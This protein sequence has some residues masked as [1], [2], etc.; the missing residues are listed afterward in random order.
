MVLIVIGSIIAA[1]GLP[2]FARGLMFTLRPEHAMSLRAR[3]RNLRLGLESDIRVWGRR[4][5]R[6]GFLL[7]AIGGT[8]IAL[9]ALR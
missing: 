9:G 5:R 8:L 6:F 4:V 1:L 3:E 7:L 2:F